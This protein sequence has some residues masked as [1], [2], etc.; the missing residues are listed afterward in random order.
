MLRADIAILTVIPEEYESVLASLNSYGCQTIHDSGSA[1]ATNLYGWVVRALT[2]AQGRVYRI[3]VGIVAQPGP[4]RMASA[5]LATVTRYKPRYILLVG[6]AGGFPQDGLARGD[7]TISTV[8]YDYEYGKVA[9]DFQPRQDF[10][11]QTDVAL[12]T[13]AI[14]LH[15]RDKSWA[16]RDQHIRP[17]GSQ[18]VP[19]LLAGSVASGSKIIDNAG[20]AFFVQVLKAWPRLLA[21]EM[22]GAGAASAIETAKAANA[23]VGFLMVRG[24][25]DMPKTG[26]R[27]HEE[28]NKAERDRWKKYAATTAANFTI[29]WISHGWPTPPRR[30]TRSPASK[31]SDDEATNSKATN[32]TQPTVLKPEQGPKELP[33][34]TL[35][36]PR[37]YI[38]AV[39]F[40][41]VT[42]AVFQ[43]SSGRSFNFSLLCVSGGC[44]AVDIWA[45]P[46]SSGTCLVLKL[47]LLESCQVILGLVSA[48]VA[49][50]IDVEASAGE[51]SVIVQGCLSVSI[52]ILWFITIKV[53]VPDALLA[54]HHQR[55]TPLLGHKGLTPL[56][57]HKA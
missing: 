55:L 4:E 25:S 3:V 18:A 9:T 33:A 45:G 37:N 48:S 6:I 39:A 53:S 34:D 32:V 14:S 23:N 5:V 41:G 43:Q 1:S 29:H 31:P 8:I 19:K 28:G 10:T 56:L 35:E 51:N 42:R 52:K 20:N 2:D 17:S 38:I 13:S 36:R 26:E 46:G 40:E 57:G 7:V 54:H 30:T 49:I 11:Y 27:Q 47:S 15:A 22:E 12:L 16:T 24:I 50:F 44:S 21:V